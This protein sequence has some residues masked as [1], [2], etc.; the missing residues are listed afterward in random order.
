[1]HEFRL[2]VPGGVAVAEQRK[3]ASQCCV[4]QAGEWV[5]CRVFLRSR[6]SRE[7]AAGSQAPGNRASLAHRTAPP[8][9]HQLDAGQLRSL[10]LSPPSLPSS[11]CV[12]GVTDISD[13]DEV[14]SSSSVRDAAGAGAS[15]R[16][17]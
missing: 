2:A 17:A 1:M 3:N 9:Q 6:M 14:S 8:L 7:D 10:L 5:V 15:Q 4:V 13:Q 12:T 11:S 16:E